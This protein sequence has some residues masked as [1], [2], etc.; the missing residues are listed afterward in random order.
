M[1]TGQ[2]P[3]PATSYSV[4]TAPAGSLGEPPKTDGGLGKFTGPNRGKSASPDPLQGLD[5]S[6]LGPK[7][8]RPKA[9]PTLAPETSLVPP[10]RPQGLTPPAPPV[11]PAY[12]GMS[13]PGEIAGAFSG[14][15]MSTASANPDVSYLRETESQ[16]GLPTNF[17]ATMWQIESS[18]SRDPGMNS[19]PY[20]GPFQLGDAVAGQFGIQDPTNFREAAVGAAKFAQTNATTLARVLGR[21]P[22]AEELYL[23]HQQGPSGAA[24]LLSN[25]DARAV[26]ILSRFHGDRATRVITGNGGRADMTAGEFAS[27]WRTRYRA[28][29][30]EAARIQG[31]GSDVAYHTGAPIHPDQTQASLGGTSR[32]NPLTGQIETS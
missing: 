28:K 13:Q 1:T 29:Q 18:S 5:P 27:L 11:R 12:L 3:K 6:T 22:T 7:G 14:L 15:D 26:D 31:W 4:Q 23:A 21:T 20:V 9:R 16:F 25:P 10:A 19:G 2:Y 24:A 8:T 30:R 32:F 17:L